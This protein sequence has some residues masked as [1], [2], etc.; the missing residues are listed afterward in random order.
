MDWIGH[1]N[2]IAHWG[3]GM[4]VSGPEEVEAIGWTQPSTDVY[5]TPVDYEIRCVYPGGVDWVMLPISPWARGGSE[6][7][8][9][10]RWIGAS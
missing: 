4:D 8:V 3:A 5:D 9:G 6:R 1:H 7:K 10:W 2:D